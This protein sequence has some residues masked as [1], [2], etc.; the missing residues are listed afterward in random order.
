[1]SQTM[2]SQLTNSLQRIFLANGGRF[3]FSKTAKNIT[4]IDTEKNARHLQHRLTA[5]KVAVLHS[6]DAAGRVI[7]LTSKK[8]LVFDTEQGKLSNTV[9]GFSE[10]RLIVQP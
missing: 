7:A 6:D 8:L 1:M 3:V 4:L 9:G 2:K 10:P 5:G